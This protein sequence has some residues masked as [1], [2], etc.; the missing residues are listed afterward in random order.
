M[1]ALTLVVLI[2]L[3]ILPRL[4]AAQIAE[5]EFVQ[6]MVAHK[7]GVEVLCV[8]LLKNFP[9]VRAS[10]AIERCRVHDVSK[11]RQDEKFL[12]R[13]GMSKEKSLASHLAEIYGRFVP[14]NQVNRGVIDE[15]NRVDAAVGRE[16]DARFRAKPSERR[17]TEIIEHV[18][19]LTERGMHESL[20]PPADGIFERGRPMS[21]ASDYISKSP[22][23]AK[24]WTESER[25]LMVALSKRLESDAKLK[26]A[27]INSMKP[28]KI[29]S[30]T[31]DLL[32]AS[33]YRNQAQ[34]RANCFEA[35]LRAPL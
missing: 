9:T 4:A 21:L 13:Y 24:M 34:V 32:A 30:Q 18:A 17:L 6:R 22:S 33:H 26:T 1:R 23:E 31:T 19:D 35:L 12:E 8:E 28:G 27:L 11:V 15:A 10:Y 3:S 16:V 2:A 5:D 20:F 7:I 29:S 25:K 14:E